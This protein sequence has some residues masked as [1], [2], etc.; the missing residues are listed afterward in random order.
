MEIL[1][2]IQKL[3]FM[4]SGCSMN[5]LAVDSLNEWL[6]PWLKPRCLLKC[7]ARLLVAKIWVQYVGFIAK[8]LSFGPLQQGITSRAR[9]PSSC[10]NLSLHIVSYSCF[11]LYI[12]GTN[13]YALSEHIS[14][15]YCWLQ[16]MR[17][18]K[19]LKISWW[20]CTALSAASTVT[21]TAPAFHPAP[22]C[23]DA[24]PL[25]LTDGD[26]GP[27]P[28]R[29]QPRL[30]PGSQQG[31]CAFYFLFLCILNQPCKQATIG[32]CMN[33]NVFYAVERK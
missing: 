20:P 33:K 14:I 8:V 28:L 22:P 10:C 11:F 15:H 32:F 6:Y 2:G 16:L 3:I 12:V 27:L 23:H 30:S 17:H 31:L 9:R 29:I 1:A 7:V 4:P 18:H 25:S 13:F 24:P 5:S 19:L 21:A 26:N